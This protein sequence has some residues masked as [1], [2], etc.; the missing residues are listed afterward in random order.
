MVIPN[1]P[2]TF[3]LKFPLRVKDPVSVSPEAKHG[4]ELVKLKLV[5]VTSVPL[6]CVSEVVNLKAGELS[7]LVSDAV[8]FPLM[9]PEFELP[10]PQALSTNPS[11]TSITIPK[12]LNFIR[13]AP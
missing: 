5:T 10:P 6:L 3:P 12:H 8:Q 4:D 1:P 11:A 7:V 9:L 13:G 2:V